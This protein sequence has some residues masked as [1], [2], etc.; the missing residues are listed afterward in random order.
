MNFV[1]WRIVIPMGPFSVKIN[2]HVMLPISNLFV[3]SFFLMVNVMMM[4][5]NDDGDDDFARRR[6]LKKIKLCQWVNDHR[7]KRLESICCC[8]IA[9]QLVP[10]IKEIWCQSQVQCLEYFHCKHNKSLLFV[11]RDLHLTLKTFLVYLVL[12]MSHHFLLTVAQQLLYYIQAYELWAFGWGF[13][14]QHYQG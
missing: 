9:H 7:I 12:W 10:S 5:N 8:W 1:T 11:L 2:K 6:V 13:G 4:M 3:F 14:P